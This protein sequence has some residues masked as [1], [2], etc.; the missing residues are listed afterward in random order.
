MGF[1]DKVKEVFGHEASDVKEGLADFGE[2]LDD[3]L[4]KKERELAASPEERFDMALEDAD[5]TNRRLEDL[6]EEAQHARANS[7]EEVPDPNG[8]PAGDSGSQTASHQLLEPHDVSSSAHLPTTMR[9]V[10][11]ETTQTADPMCT[12]CGHAAWIEE[13][14]SKLLGSELEVVASQVNDHPLVTEVVLEDREVLYVAAPSLHTEDVR[15]LVA[16]AMAD[17]LPSGWRTKTPPDLS[18]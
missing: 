18:V 15:L 1:W 6:V 13:S 3:A 11:V 9:W 14:A 12:R 2:K 5:V 8:Q 7:G 17:R 10:T 16:A 4:A